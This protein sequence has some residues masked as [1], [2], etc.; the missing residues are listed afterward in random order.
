MVT[1]DDSQELAVIGE[2][3][4]HVRRGEVHLHWFSGGSIYN[5]GEGG[6]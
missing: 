2:K 3:L 5:P 1:H 6:H 4:E